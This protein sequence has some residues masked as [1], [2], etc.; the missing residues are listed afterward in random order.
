VATVVEALAS[1]PPDAAGVQ[2]VTELC[3]GFLSREVGAL[4]YGI[5]TVGRGGQAGRLVTDNLA[6]RGD[7]IRR[8]GFEHAS[9]GT[10]VDSLLL[11]R[12]TDA[13]YHV[14]LCEGLRMRHSYPRTWRVGVPWFLLRAWAV[15]YFM[16]RTRQ[17]EP[18]FRGSALIRMAGLGW[19]VVVG[20]KLVRDLAQ[21]WEH[22]RRVGARFALA[23]PLALAFEVTLLSGGLAALL[24]LPAP[25]IS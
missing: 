5:R 25:K 1:A 23:L 21:V 8:F 2:G 12:L 24:R 19:P 6:F 15:G 4:L 14:L 20:A 13:G 7:V 11:Q 16:V 9:F 3:R 22:R 10:V 17:L 18:R